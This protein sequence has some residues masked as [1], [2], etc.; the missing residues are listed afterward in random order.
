MSESG[1][2][3][4]DLILYFYPY[5]YRSLFLY[6]FFFFLK[7]VIITG[8]GIT[9]SI[10]N[11]VHGAFFGG[12]VVVV[13]SIAQE[14]NYRRNMGTTAYCPLS[15]FTAATPPSYFLLVLYP[16]IIRFTCLVP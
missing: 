14:P 9:V 12:L 3:F 2:I 15:R 5:L 11:I 6:L 1:Y 13:S 4:C 16:R 7:V 10:K 8:V